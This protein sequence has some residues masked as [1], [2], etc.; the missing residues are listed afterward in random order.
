[1]VVALNPAIEA[2]MSLD[3]MGGFKCSSYIPIPIFWIDKAQPENGKIPAVDTTHAHSSTCSGRNGLAK[4]R[5][6][7]IT[8]QEH[9]LAIVLFK[10]ETRKEPLLRVRIFHKSVSG[11]Y[12]PIHGPSLPCMHRSSL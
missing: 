4:S 2:K 12:S 5:F 11:W 10:V 1:M 6:L 8:T 7:N 9:L 3:F